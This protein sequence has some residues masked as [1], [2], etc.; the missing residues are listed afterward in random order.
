MKKVAV[1][2]SGAWGTTL[3]QVMVDSGQQV[4]IWGRNKKVVREINRRHSNRRFLKGIDLPRELKA[5]TGVNYPVIVSIINDVIVHIISN[6]AFTIDST[7]AITGFTDLQKGDLIKFKIRG[8]P[9]DFIGIVT[10]VHSDPFILD[11]IVCEIFLSQDDY[12]Y[13]SECELDYWILLNK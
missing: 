11:E 1:L 7:S 3:G 8:H 2:G 6:T 4:L 5:T 9:G 13:L 12:V 10:T